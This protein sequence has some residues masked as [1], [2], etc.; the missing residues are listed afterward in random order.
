M[1]WL[2]TSTR[3]LRRDESGLVVVEAAFIY[4][5]VFAILIFLLLVCDMFYQRAWIEAAVQQEAVEGAQALGDSQVEN[6][7][8]GEAS[9]KGTL[10]TPVP[11][12]PYRFIFGTG[13][14]DTVG[15]R[16]NALR[17]RIENGEGSILGLAPTIESV[18]AKA[19]S[20]FLYSDYTVSVRYSFTLG[21][22][23][24]VDEKGSYDVNLDS[25]AIAPIL[26]T[27]ETIRNTDIVDD[28]YR[29]AKEE[30]G[31]GDV[32]DTLT[33]LGDAVQGFNDTLCGVV[34]C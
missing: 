26:S 33:R 1:S 14:G 10:H 6:I 18:E 19:S 32:A 31:L 13:R 7:S 20:G 3:R 12:D 15:E 11:N 8:V 29:R 17:D 16:K 34:P 21:I 27:G 9:G 4:P 5:V 25:S 24:F 30:A 23:R 28:Y 22:A 2:R